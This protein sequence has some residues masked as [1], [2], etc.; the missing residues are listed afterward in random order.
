[1]EICH[2]LTIIILQ[3][4]FTS[5]LEEM[6]T[7]ELEHMLMVMVDY[8]DLIIVQDPILLLTCVFMDIDLQD[9]VIM[10]E[11]VLTWLLQAINSAIL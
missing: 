5:L 2:F 8:M 3:E 7:Q 9:H 6:I 1:M 11:L 4:K 10:E